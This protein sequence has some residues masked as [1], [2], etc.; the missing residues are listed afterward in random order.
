MHDMASLDQLARKQHGLVTVGQM[1]ALQIT[2][3]AIEHQ[4]SRGQL[5]RARRGVYR[6]CGVPL[7]WHGSVLAV[8]LAAG[9]RTVLSHASA[10]RLWELDD[11][12]RMPDCI[13][14]TS[15]VRNR[16][17][18]VVVHRGT[19]TAPE[20]TRHMGIPVTTVERT[21]LDM[22]S[23]V[24]PIEIGTMIDVALRRRLTTI[25]RLRATYAAGSTGVGRPGIASLREALADRDLAYDPGANGWELRMD[26]MW[27]ELG[28]P[29]A[30]RQYRI[31]CAGRTY[32]PDRAIVELKVAV[33]WNGY[34]YHGS[35]SRFDYDSDRRARMSAAGWYPLDF[36]S[37]STPE[38]ICAAVLSVCA[39]R[40]ALA[41]S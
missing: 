13:E 33:D 30:Q 14:V 27:V 26:S 18:G 10:V 5:V 24:G 7:S 41:S 17:P 31:R 32:R 21:I 6:L 20:S 12:P 8:V 37:R 22:G 4:M 28:L 39:E 23:R 36:T 40:R 3:T 29:A 19:L 11:G 25:R 16:Q 1:H 35:R 2:R 38:L 15:L 9:G 34:E